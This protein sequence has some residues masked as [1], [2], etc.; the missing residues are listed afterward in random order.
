M[1]KTSIILTCA[2]ALMA[3]S[4]VAAFAAPNNV[5]V[6]S[7]AKSDN[8]LEGL[9]LISVDKF[10]QKDAV[11]TTTYKTADEVFAAHGGTTKRVDLS[12]LPKNTAVIKVNTVDELDALLSGVSGSLSGE[13][14]NVVISPNQSQSNDS[15]NVSKVSP[16]AYTSSKSSN[17]YD[18][19]T[20]WV[21]LY[22]NYTV[23]NAGIIDV[24]AY[25]ALS[26]LTLGVTWNQTSA[27]STKISSKQWLTKGSGT[28]NLVI[29]IE[30]IGTVYSENVSGS[31]YVTVS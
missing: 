23:T 6:S 14:E 15:N 31:H 9:N 4:P 22:S 30:G 20:W 11:K 8:S 5:E 12:S 26:G 13:G 19:K 27:T 21:R 10:V 2:L 1:K 16:T 25:T 24:Q 18:A 28:Y 29:F 7:Q 17:L 3:V